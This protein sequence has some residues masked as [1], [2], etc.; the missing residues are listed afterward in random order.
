MKNPKNQE[1]TLP[2]LTK[3]FW[4]LEMVIL[5]EKS[6]LHEALQGEAL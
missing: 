6:S 4:V 2:A 3:R 5:K 1:E